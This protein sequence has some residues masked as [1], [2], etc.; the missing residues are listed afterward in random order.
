MPTREAR[1]AVVSG[2]VRLSTMRAAIRHV[3]DHGH[4]YDALGFVCPG[5]VE[6]LSEAGR[7]A[8]GLHV[9][10][11]EPDRNGLFWEWDGNLEAPTLT[12]S[13]L[14]HIGDKACHSYLTAGVF[15]FLEDSAHSMA[16][17]HVEMPDLPE[18]FT[19]PRD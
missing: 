3:N 1:T 19:R 14:T 11:I 4:E 16:G 12:P 7:L 6:L 10:P 18:W 9:L 17:Q 2:T 5:C 15:H 8:S 13:I